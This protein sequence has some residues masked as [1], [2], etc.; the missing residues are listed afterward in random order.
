MEVVAED[1]CGEKSVEEAY[2]RRGRYVSESDPPGSKPPSATASLCTIRQTEEM[3]FAIK[4]FPR[5][6]GSGSCFL[7]MLLPALVLSPR[8]WMN[9]PFVGKDSGGRAPSMTMAQLG[10]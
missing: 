3:S 4:Q 7:E 10:C 5:Q 2:R 8:L 6:A 1:H 9:Q